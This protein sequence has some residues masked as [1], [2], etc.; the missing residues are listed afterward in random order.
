MPRAKIKKNPIRNEAAD[1]SWALDPVV[2]PSL[3]WLAKARAISDL[4]KCQVHPHAGCSYKPGLSERQELCQCST[5]AAYISV[6]G[7]KKEGAIFLRLCCY[8]VDLN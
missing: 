1:F 7:R 5:P 6:Q 4:W 2:S 3:T 8:T